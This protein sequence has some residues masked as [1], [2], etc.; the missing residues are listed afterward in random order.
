[1]A[2]LLDL[3]LPGWSKTEAVSKA[4]GETT[5]I[6]CASQR[7]EGLHPQGYARDNSFLPEPMRAT[8][9]ISA[10]APE[11]HRPGRSLR[12]RLSRPRLSHAG[13]MHLRPHASEVASRISRH[14]VLRRRIFSRATAAHRSLPR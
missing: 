6:L 1:M 4:S 11:N 14:L 12:I 7:A 9:P 13:C 5:K 2:R 8:P 10:A 3:V